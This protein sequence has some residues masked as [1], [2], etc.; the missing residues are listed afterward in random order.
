MKK[1]Q[2]Y[3]E[4][5]PQ[6]IKLMSQDTKNA[7]LHFLNQHTRELISTRKTSHKQIIKT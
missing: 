5:R 7:I 1:G 3:S 2:K 6:H 4:E